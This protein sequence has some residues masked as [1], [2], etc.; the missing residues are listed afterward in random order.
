VW[1]AKAIEQDGNQPAN[2]NVVRSWKTPLAELPDCE[3][4]DRAI[5]RLASWMRHKGPTWLEAFE[6]ALGKR[7]P[8]PSPNPS[9]KAPPKP[10]PT[11]SPKQ[12]QEQ[13]QE[14]EQDPPNPHRGLNDI[15]SRCERLV[16][17]PYDA[18]F[19]QPQTWPEILQAA[20]ILHTGL[21]FTG[22]PKLG[23]FASDKGLKR[24]VELFTAGF[25]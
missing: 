2:P 8:M 24:I 1:V 3:L 4:K 7:A 5:E 15:R 16:N 18:S 21:G 11:P 9:G 20:E 6:E 17:N 23:R 14:Q 13:E 19:E 10:L 12:E 25:S 22:K